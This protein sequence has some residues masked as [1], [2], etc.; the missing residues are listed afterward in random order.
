MVAQAAAIR[1]IMDDTAEVADIIQRYVVSVYESFWDRT[2]EV[3][4]KG[5]QTIIHKKWVQRLPP[6]TWLQL[7]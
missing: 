7:R 3:T 5:N 1:S 2:C 6:S 4:G